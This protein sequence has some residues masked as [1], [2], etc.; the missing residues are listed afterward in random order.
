MKKIYLSAAVIAATSMVSAQVKQV[1]TTRE[2]FEQPRETVVSVKEVNFLNGKASGDIVWQEDFANGLPGNNASAPS[3]WTVGGP[4]P[5]WAYDLDGPNGQYSAT[6]QR[7]TSTTVNN[8]FI[9]FDAD[10]A[11]PGAPSTFTDQVGFIESPA[12]D[13]TGFANL[14]LTFQHTYRTCC[15]NGFFPQVVVSDDN[16]ATSTSFNV[17]IPGILVNQAAPTTTQKVQLSSFIAGM[18]NPT[19]LKFRF[20]FDGIGGTSHYWW[21]VDDIAI[22]EQYDN[23]LRMDSRVLGMGNFQLPYHF[24]PATQLVPVSI[25]GEVYND[26]VNPQTGTQL[27]F[28][29]VTGGNPTVLTSNAVTLNP[30]VLDSLI[31]SSTWS[32]LATAGTNYDLT[33]R[34]IQTQTEEF[35]ADNQRTD[36]FRVT[37]TVFAVDNNS[38]T[39]SFT[40][41]VGNTSNA[42]KIGNVMEFN[43]P[44]W[45]TSISVY[46]ANSQASV[47]QE[48]FGEIRRWDGADYVFEEETD[49]RQVVAGNLGQF[50]TMKLKTP[51][52]VATGDDILV[53][54]GHNGS[55][56]PA[57]TDPA[58]GLSRTVPGGSVLGYDAADQLFGLA[59]PRA[60]MV[61]ANINNSV[62]L[63]EISN[64]TLSVSNNFPNP[65]A[66]TTTV[67]F[68]LTNATNVSYDVV[69]MT[70]KTVLSVNNGNMAAGSHQIKLDGTSWANGIYYFTVKTDDAQITRKIVV[71]K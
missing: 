34:A 63:E 39:G 62:S 43:A 25:S 69:D 36:I 10:A 3:T 31:T 28:T 59:S 49:F 11:Q 40:N 42:I 22:I 46:M 52:Q 18:S 58:F 4:N 35:P 54:V 19:N 2:A 21:Q 56:N 70:G 27:E 16:F 57:V 17:S 14:T 41:I 24:V 67:D 29:A 23:D 32:P 61:R 33:W 7:I 37:D 8:G 68:K 12:I 53:L 45:I 65:F 48:I 38:I 26:G 1:A 9:I 5:I 47:G 66:T 50:I 71:N 6:T 64:N 51:V 30:G 13:V 20:L 55:G 60:V 15:A 44:T